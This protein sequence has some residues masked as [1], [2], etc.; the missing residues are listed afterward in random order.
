MEQF[1]PEQIKVLTEN[2]VIPK[3]AQP[4]QIAY[5]F[6]V[7]KRKKL[8]PFTKQIHMIERNERDG[9][10]WKKSYTIQASIDG[11]RAI[12]QRNG[13]IHSIKRYVKR[14][15]GILYGC[16]EIVTKSGG[17]YSDELSVNEYI[18]KKKDGNPT[19]FWSRMPETMI[20][21]CAEESVLRMVSPEDLSGVYGDDEMLQ[22]DTEQIFLPKTEEIKADHP[23]LESTNG[24]HDQHESKP[25]EQPKTV[26]STKNEAVSFKEFDPNTEIM[27]FGKKYAGQEWMLV[28]KSYLQWMAE[29][30]SG[31]NQQK[32][33]LTLEYMEKAE[34]Q[35][36][37]I[38]DLDAVFGKKD[39]PKEEI[40]PM[41]I[42]DSEKKNKALLAIAKATTKT[43]LNKI[44]KQA[45][46]YADTGEI[47]P[48]T[49]KAIGEWIA[50]RNED[51]KLK[52]KV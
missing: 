32:A 10:N 3:D 49:F 28:D 21:K 22:A 36:P 38:D 9:D 20:K 12:A 45:C 24:N 23:K 50:K 37:V 7:C 16:C 17:T 14:D 26:Q 43:E 42:D 13:T 11:M 46:D 1:T 34:K 25:Q 35:E 5:F 44:S 33:K 15:N 2:K 47:T 39:I 31:I 8:D 41:A 27:T 51:I 29:S 52:G 48:E 40:K 6:E 19:A 4:L 30:A 18:Q